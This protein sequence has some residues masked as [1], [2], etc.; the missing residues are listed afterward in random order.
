[1]RALTWSAG[2]RVLAVAI[3]LGAS[4]VYGGCSSDD[5]GSASADAGAGDGSSQS[6]VI[7]PPPSD[8]G[9]GDASDA[10]APAC[11][12]DGGLPDELRCTGLYASFAAKTLAP[13][14]RP[15]APGAPFWSDGADKSRWVLLPQGT[16][17]DTSNMDEW[18][19][20]NGTKLWKEFRVGGKRV[21]TR[22]FSKTAPPDPGSDAGAATNA[23]W[24]WTT[25]R[26][27][28]DESTATRLDNGASNVNGTTYEIPSH[29][30]CDQ[31]HSG[32]TDRIL[33]F[34][35][36]NMGLSA[37]T[38]VTLAVLASEGRLTTAPA[39]T[40]F[41]IPEDAT[42]KARDA[43]AWL[44]GNCGSACHNGNQNA[45]ALFTGLFLRVRTAE[46]VADGGAARVQDLDA[47]KTSV[48]QDPKS[49][50]VFK[51]QGFK[52]IAAHDVA[53]SLIPKLA[54]ARNV[55]GVPQMPPIVTH[56][57]DDA[58]IAKIDDWISG[59]PDAG[60]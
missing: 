5:G 43:L 54:A 1:M 27:S 6:D 41:A 39:T 4:A 20:P 37:A 53:R 23:T 47:Y 11:E 3:V 35:A 36:L 16:K 48:N 40:T 60:L 42:G 45:G 51:N 14:V 25:Y 21:E 49:L 31:C 33:G 17:I 52:L 7:V 55:S 26:W 44:H 2:T 22:I 30:Q 50:T 9:A 15:Y 46:L 19:F 24:E 57:V 12:S 59:L 58:G 10:N 18:S 34:E 13:N 38:G 28:G 56:L 32:K 29:S 8:G